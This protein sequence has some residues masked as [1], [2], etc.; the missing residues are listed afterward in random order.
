MRPTRKTLAPWVVAV[1]T[2]LVAPPSVPAATPIPY[3]QV[4]PLQQLGLLGLEETLRQG[5]V[6]LQ[7]PQLASVFI[8]DQMIG[9]LVALEA[10]RHRP[11]QSSLWAQRA[12]DLWDAVEPG[13][14]EAQ[15]FYAKTIP[16]PQPSVCI[17]LA[18]NGWALRATL[19]LKRTVL[20]ADPRID[21]RI[22]QVRDLLTDLLLKGSYK[23]VPDCDRG[24]GGEVNAF[25]HPIALW[26]LLEAR[27][28]AP[29]T[30]SDTA[31]RN[32]IQTLLRD[33]YEGAFV[34]AGLLNNVLNAH[35]LVVLTQAEREFNVTAMRQA[36]D[37]VAAFLQNATIQDAAGQFVALDMQRV[38]GQTRSVGSGSAPNQMW[39]AY[40]LHNYPNASRIRAELVPGLLATY[41]QRYW[42]SEF[43]AF[44]SEASFP[45]FEANALPA[46][47][48]T[49][50]ILSSV[51]TDPPTI[52]YL[53]P[54]NPSFTYP[55]PSDLCGTR[56]CSSLYYVTNSWVSRFTL[57][58]VPG[59]PTTVLLPVPDLGAFNLSALTAVGDPAP[60]LLKAQGSPVPNLD[61]PLAFAG[62]RT[63]L[64][65]FNSALSP[66]P[67]IFRFEAW[68]P[69]VP[70]RS[71]FR[72][73]LRVFVRSLAEEP[74]TLRSLQ[75]DVDATGVQADG[76]TLNDRPLGNV[77]VV[78]SIVTEFLDRPH[79]RI[80]LNEITLLPGQ[81]AQ[82][83]ITY[84]D[85]RPP[86]VGTPSLSSDAQGTNPLGNST[87]VP[88]LRGA[89]VYVRA[90][91][92]DNA[93]LRTVILRYQF[94]PTTG[95][96]AMTPLPDQPDLYV[97]PLP[98]INETGRGIVKVVAVDA[99]GN[100]HQSEDIHVAI[101]NPLFS[102]SPVLFVFSATLFLSTFV[103]WL[104]VRRR[105]HGP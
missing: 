5:D 90:A 93:V 47:L 55:R 100:L 105:D 49:A 80:T 17:D 21:Q 60:R 71:E 57:S 53:V 41:L 88:A 14:Y 29:S 4:L 83:E 98:H 68:A 27:R 9:V 73:T 23:D 22:L 86:T 8:A 13:F 92:Q 35:M 102:G 25:N 54:S 65:Q 104:K 6:Y 63:D 26:A 61:V 1:F 58:A 91:V 48:T 30:A 51:I 12:Q 101:T 75:F 56:R 74:L 97:A 79:L 40:A 50:P 59:G 62:D 70:V 72:E 81:D 77:Q 89:P 42:S 76:I 94:G 67:A 46:L 87:P 10:T 2:F 43:H 7:S 39:T 19:A 11:D 3:G 15:G 24:P 52:A 44:A 69:V 36:R 78:D 99:A 84:T 96:V 82:I 33:S 34:I 18:T 38:D 85:H 95:D 37:E 16:P 28:V 32:D 103:I 45:Y 31:V 64:L 66:A 20:P